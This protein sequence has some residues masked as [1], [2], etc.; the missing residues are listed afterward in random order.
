MGIEHMKSPE[1]I[2]RESQAE[3]VLAKTKVKKS[4][5]FEE[6][7]KKNAEARAKGLIVC[8]KCGNTYAEKDSKTSKHWGLPGCPVCYAPNVWSIPK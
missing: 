3:D 5:E 8:C 7:Q 4:K 6:L 2:V 1:T